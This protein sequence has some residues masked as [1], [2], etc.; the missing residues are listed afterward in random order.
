MKI[1]EFMKFSNK[2]GFDISDEIFDWG[3]Y[4]EVDN[5]LTL[6]KADFYDI[7]MVYFANN[8]EMV[9]YNEDWYSCCKVSEF[10]Q[11]HRKA[12]DKFMEDCNS[13]YYKPNENVT[14][15]DEEFFDLYI[16]TF[17]NLINGNYAE[18]DYELLYDLLIEEVE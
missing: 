18:E 3:N 15:D 8:I 14:I 12:F 10:I 11:K 6:Q 9:N 17:A 4:F 7:V 2:W 1:Y 5:N 16:S 13:E